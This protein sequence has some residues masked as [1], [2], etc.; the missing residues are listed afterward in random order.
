MRLNASSPTWQINSHYIKVQMKNKKDHS[1]TWLLPYCRITVHVTIKLALVQIKSLAPAENLFGTI[2]SDWF[3]SVGRN[4]S[5]IFHTHIIRIPSLISVLVWPS[6]PEFPHSQIRVRTCR[7]KPGAGLQSV[8]SHLQVRQQIFHDIY[9]SLKS[10]KC[11]SNW[12]ET[13]NDST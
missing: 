2:T 5:K 9:K 12:A 11:P 8:C 3:T 6:C 1:R 10:G 7:W 4:H 13:H